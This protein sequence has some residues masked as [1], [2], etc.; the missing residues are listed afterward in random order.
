MAAVYNH[1][2]DCSL[3]TFYFYILLL[4]CTYTLVIVC[5]ITIKMY[6][7]SCLSV[8]GLGTAYNIVIVTNMCRDFKVCNTNEWI[9]YF[10]I[11]SQ[12]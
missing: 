11:E 4:T 1:V 9:Y 5:I 8:L 6:P 3:F 2:N 7:Q 12:F 10:E